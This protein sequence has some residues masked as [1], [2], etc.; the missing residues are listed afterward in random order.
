METETN[1]KKHAIQLDKIIVNEASFKL[2]EVMEGAQNSPKPR[3]FVGKSE[4]NKQ[5][6]SISV[7][8]MVRIEGEQFGYSC[9]IEIIGLFI[10]NEN[11]FDISKIDEWSHKN[12]PYILHPY[13][14][15]HLFNLTLNATGNGFLLP[16][17]EVPTSGKEINS[18]I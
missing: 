7:G 13:I 10:V 6:H 11:D 9:V 3:F 17:I 12:A 8:L 15:Q 16:L 4:Y 5:D 18:I 1:F 14:R 2:V